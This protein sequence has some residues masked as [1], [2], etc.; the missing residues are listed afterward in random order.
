MQS[1]PDGM[2]SEE[3]EA[4]KARR[5][6]VELNLLRGVDGTRLSGI[7]PDMLSHVRQK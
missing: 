3:V 4:L 2:R 7:A 1:M 6:V 5:L